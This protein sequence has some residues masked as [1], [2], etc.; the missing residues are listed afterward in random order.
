MPEDIAGHD[1]EPSSADF[2]AAEEVLA[3]LMPALERDTPEYLE[4]RRAL[5]AYRARIGGERFDLYYGRRRPRDPREEAEAEF[6]QG[7]ITEEQFAEMLRAEAERPLDAAM[8]AAFC[9]AYEQRLSAYS[10]MLQA[11]IALATDQSRPDTWRR[12]EAEVDRHVAA[13]EAKLPLW[14]EQIAAVFSFLAELQ[15][16]HKGEP[17]RCGEHAAESAHMLAAMVMD[18]A[19]AGWRSV[20]EIAQRSRSDPRYSRA[21]SAA[22]LFYEAHLPGLPR[23]QELQAL[24][25]LEHARARKVLEERARAAK[26]HPQI[27]AEVNIKAEA[28]KVTTPS[29]Q[30][31][32][33]QA[34]GVGRP[35]SQGRVKRTVVELLI[36]R[37][38][39][40]RP[41]DTAREVAAAVGCSVGLVAESKAWRAN[42]RRLQIAAKEGRDPKA[43]KLDVR[44][45][46]EDGGSERVQRHAF[47]EAQEA[48]DAEM[49][50]REKELF[51]RIGEYQ[52]KHPGATP[53]EVARALGCTVGDVERRQAM[54]ERLLAE[55]SES[56]QEETGAERFGKRKGRPEGENRQR[57]I[58]RQV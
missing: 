29:V 56:A 32:A 25:V 31:V 24:M 9:D 49:D 10:R 3:R 4:K 44:A 34:S 53:Q 43:V 16:E 47:R 21:A 42:R 58:R 57:W 7:R 20:K 15:A 11:V 1:W 52:A 19:A 8:L 28:V 18:Q 40:R 37:H 38:L 41:H 50:A 46:T 45:V 2:A 36:L 17:V 33:E 5:A 54:L 27:P 6:F 13:M 26:T 51:G 39:V 12:H 55:Q 22:R 23:P 48:Q 35:Q 30:V 14:R